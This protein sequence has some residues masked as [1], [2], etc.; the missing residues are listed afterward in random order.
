MLKCFKSLFVSHVQA[1]RVKWIPKCKDLFNS[2]CLTKDGLI[3]RQ[4]A[5]CKAETKTASLRRL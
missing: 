4:S 1:L 3:H 5:R 2:D